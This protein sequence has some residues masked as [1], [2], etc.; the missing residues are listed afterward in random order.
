ME[1]NDCVNS[2]FEQS[3]WFE[4]VVPGEWEE[5]VIKS[6]DIIDARWIY[7]FHNKKIIMPKLTQS[8]GIWIRD[9]EGQ[10]V[11]ESLKHKK[12]RL[13]EILNRLPEISSVDVS[14]DSNNEYF[15]PF[16][17]ENFT[18]TPRISYRIDLGNDLDTIFGSFSKNLKRDI[19]NAQKKLHISYEPSGDVLYDIMLKTFK[20]QNRIYPISKELIERILINSLEHN[21]G[22][23]ITALDDD[24]NVHASGFFLYDTNRCYYLIGGKD[25][26]YKNSNGLSLIIWKGI[27]YAAS[28]SKVFDF[29]GSMIEGIENFFQRFGGIPVTYYNIRK[30]S[31]FDSLKSISKPY[32]KR[33]LKYKV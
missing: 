22:K 18:V 14:L 25:I 23:M 17:W 29:E 19:K 13:Q 20:E 32:I 2:I 4:T 30:M 33:L 6:G 21:A 9:M 31:W 8:A 5:I 7:C 10:C 15:L 11:R 1:V 26:N 27:Q 24:N 3:W 16:Y 28:V 12:E